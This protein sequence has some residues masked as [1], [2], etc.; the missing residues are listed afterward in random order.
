MIN[1]QLAKELKDAGFPQT[2]GLTY[3][4]YPGVLEK[5]SKS[6]TLLM[7]WREDKGVYTPTLSELIESCQVHCDH[8]MLECKSGCVDFETGA[9]DIKFYQ[10]LYRADGVFQVFNGD[11]PSEAVAKLWLALHNK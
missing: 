11:T 8:F 3:P 6:L 7:E 9:T 5:D 2:G 1:Y 4:E 10:A